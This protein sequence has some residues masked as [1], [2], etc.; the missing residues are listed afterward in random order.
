[1]GVET[2]QGSEGPASPSPIGVELEHFC[3]LNQKHLNTLIYHPTKTNLYVYSVGSIV[4]VED[5]DD[6]HSQKFLRGHDADVTSIALSGQSLLATGQS[7]SLSRKG[8][9]APVLI[10]ELEGSKMQAVKEFTGLSLCVVCLAFSPDGRF[11]LGSGSNCMLFVWDMS[12]CE[13][14]Y[15]RKTDTPLFAGVWGPLQQSTTSRYPSY[16]LMTAF[17][18]QVLTHELAFDLRSMSYALQSNKCQTP[19][20]G[21]QR[22]HVAAIVLGDLLITGTH[23]G[24]VCVFNYKNGIF[25]ASLP[26]VNGGVCGLCAIGSMVYVA[27]GDGRV[28]GFQVV[29]DVHWD[30]VCENVINCA[31]TS[32]VFLSSLTP[33]ADGRE[34]M[35]GTIDGRIWRLLA[36]DLTATLHS[37]VHSGLVSQAAF[38]KS[39]D[40]F[41]TCSLNGEIFMWSLSDYSQLWIARSKSPCITVCIAEGVHV[42]GPTQVLAGYEDGF[43]RCWVEGKLLWEKANAHRGPITTIAESSRYII[44]GGDDSMVRVWHRNTRE[45]IGQYASHQSK[46]RGIA[47]LIIDNT[48]SHIFHSASVDK[49]VVTYDLKTN[50]PIVV[51]TT[52]NSNFSG[53]SQRKDHENEIIT[54]SHD[55][56]IL[57]WDVDV[58]EAVG[59]LQVEGRVRLLCC[60]I[61]PQGRFLSAGGDNG[62]LYIFDLS[63]C[64]CVF[65]G[66]GHSSDITTA[67]WS[68]DERQ[69]VTV[70]QDGVVIWNVFTP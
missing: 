15:S 12:T 21:L 47:K 50:K 8:Q 27:G 33:S 67:T 26:V 66:Q 53:L 19:A 14:V 35:C 17:D 63:S 28:K 30:V 25:R 11:L 1:M 65:Q 61:S 58:S 29:S 10:W 70:A 22:K 4:I 48:S 41:A 6:P 36:T 55:G 59:C 39:S 43:V 56:K 68:P 7:G 40:V 51:H 60:E 52:P 13:V 18:T 31:I 57:F 23:A 42:S 34:L 45:L 37:S 38:G 16:N 46:G 54:C 2:Q 3:G 32:G 5:V 49:L 44:T 69:L 9:V 62:V 64:T 24:D 20:S